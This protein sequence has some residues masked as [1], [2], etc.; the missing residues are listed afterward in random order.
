MLWCRLSRSSDLVISPPHIPPP[1][2]GSSIV[3]NT[4]QSDERRSPFYTRNILRSPLPILVPSPPRGVA[5]DPD[6]EIRRFV[7]L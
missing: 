5:T 3:S 6:F 4:S 7:C 2:L 1:T